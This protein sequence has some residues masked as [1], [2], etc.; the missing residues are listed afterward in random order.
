[1]AILR[2]VGYSAEKIFAYAFD[3]AGNFSEEVTYEVPTKKE[4]DVVVKAP[5]NVKKSKQ[6][7][8]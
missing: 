7:T 8:Q 5:A 3:E 2:A 1:M 4:N 6:L